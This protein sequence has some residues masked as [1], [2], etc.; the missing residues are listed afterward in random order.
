MR[1]LLLSTNTE[2]LNMAAVAL[3]AGFVAAATRAAGH[4]VHFVDLLLSDDPE[5]ALAG[6]VAEARPEVIGLSVRNIDDQCRERPTLLLARVRELVARLRQR[7]PGVPV[8]LGGAG[9]S[10]FP[11]E[12]LAYL[13]ADYG[14]AGE[15]EEVFPRLLERLERGE[16]PAGLPGVFGREI[17]APLP[18]QP[19]ADL[20][21]LPPPELEQWLER[22]PRLLGEDF[23][24][25]V[26]SR[27]GCPHR[28]SYC[29]TPA[30]QGCTLRHRPPE[31]VAAEVARLAAAGIQKLYFVDNTFNVPEAQAL[32]ICR[33]IA[34]LGVRWRCIVYPQRLSEELAAAMAGAGCVSVALG[35]ESGDP[36]VLRGLNKHFT[37]EQVVE[38]N[39]RLRR[40]G[41]GRVGFL[42]LGVPSETH[43]S[44]E[45]S[46][47]FVESLALDALR[48]TIG[49]RIYPH[50][51]LQRLAVEQGVIAPDEPLLLPRFYLASEVDP[52][53]Y[54][55]VKEGMVFNPPA[56]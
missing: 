32:A 9:Y 40:H 41:I 49:V 14:V 30:I 16:S 21:A 47:A 10:I 22:G 50:T 34:P 55:R 23:W 42:L 13:G 53:I 44:V 56:S 1:V 28:C 33:L 18:A 54:G 11:E 39:A 17:A 37:P 27:R 48:I 31:Q 46:L 12:A 43:A 51:E 24:M 8:V 19:I 29:S 26:Q 38:V 15:G 25:P 35:C 5:Q 45:R 7:C 3:G 36:G 4:E 20:A 52:W 2:T 6:A